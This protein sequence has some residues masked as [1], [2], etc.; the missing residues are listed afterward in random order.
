[1]SIPSEPDPRRTGGWR[2]ADRPSAYLRGAAEQPIEWYPWGTEPF[3]L[4]RR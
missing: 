4:A 3:E 2:L 1:M